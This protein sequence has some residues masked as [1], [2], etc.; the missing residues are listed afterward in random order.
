MQFRHQGSRRSAKTGT[1][2]IGF[3][4][5]LTGPLAGFASGDQYVLSQIRSTPEY[6]NGIKAGG[7]T[8]KVSIVVQDSQSDPNRAS[9]VAR[10]LIL[11]NKVDMILTTSTPETTN[12]VAGAC[13]KL[14]TP[15]VSTVVPVG[16]LVRGPGRQP[17]AADYD[18]QVLHVCSSSA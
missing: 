1:I 6:K 8:Y 16:I 17:G 10:Q 7:K 4:T 9:A 3:I 12:P 2:T 18:V 13:E 5:P 11:Q 14:G 15:C